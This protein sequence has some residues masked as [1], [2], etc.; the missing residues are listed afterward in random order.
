MVNEFN[1]YKD[2]LKK[3]SIMVRDIIKQYSKLADEIDEMILKTDE[4][5]SNQVDSMARMNMEMERLIQKSI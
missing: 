5:A 2:H 4:I 1:L 3:R